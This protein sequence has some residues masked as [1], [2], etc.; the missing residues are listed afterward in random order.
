MRHLF[1]L[2]EVFWLQVESA[3]V[4]VNRKQRFFGDGEILARS[5]VYD[6]ALAKTPIQLMTP[7][8]G[9]YDAVPDPEDVVAEAV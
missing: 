3:R 8:S 5:H 2:P 6:L 9:E 4:E 7:A 1:D